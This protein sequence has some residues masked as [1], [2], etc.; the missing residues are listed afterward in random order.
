VVEARHAD[1]VREHLQEQDAAFVN[2][3]TRRDGAAAN[4]T[5]MRPAAPEA[6]TWT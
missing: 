5:T 2:A 1:L 6:D 3:W 4:T